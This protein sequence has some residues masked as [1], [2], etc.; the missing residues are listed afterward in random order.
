M[1]LNSVHV[2]EWEFT[3]SKQFDVYFNFDDHS[4][5]MVIDQ[6]EDEKTLVKKLRQLIEL[7]ESGS[8]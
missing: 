7:I 1:K 3:T 5:S 4:F 8:A 6:N 2:E